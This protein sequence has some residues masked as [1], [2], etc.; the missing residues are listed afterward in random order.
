ML[1]SVFTHMLPRDLENYLSEIVRVMQK[2]G[3][4]AITYFL[5]NQESLRLIAGGKSTLD[6]KHAIDQ[7]R[8]VSLDV[9][10]IAIA[11]DESWIKALYEKNGL[12]IERLDYGSWC[13]RQRY[14][15]YQDM[16]FASKA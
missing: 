7:Y 8:V 3:R 5:L 1:G 2:G 4:C 12:R 6:L 10:E 11:F 16:I 9:P 14:V 15:S 13:G